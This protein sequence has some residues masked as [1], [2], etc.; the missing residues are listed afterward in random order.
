L[1]NIGIVGKVKMTRNC[2]RRMLIG[3]AGPLMVIIACIELLGIM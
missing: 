2:L 3:A 1:M